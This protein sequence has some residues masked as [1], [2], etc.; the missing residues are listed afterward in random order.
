MSRAIVWKSNSR[1]V[2]DEI[3]NQWTH[4]LGFA[5]SLPAGWWLF[6]TTRETGD[7]WLVAGC[8]IYSVTLSLLYAA[9]MLSHSLHR[10]LWRHRF[11]TLDQICIFLLMAG[12]YTPF[13][14]TY[15]RNGWWG[16]LLIVMWLLALAGITAKVFFTRVHSVS[17]WFY[18]LVGWV[19]ALALPHY[20]RCLGT[21]GVAW[22]FASA[23]AY[24]GGTWFFAN[25]HRPYFHPLWHL[26]VMLGSACHYVL[27]L[28]YIVGCAIPS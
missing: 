20:F 27:T 23:A 25:D 12:S 17:V 28:K 13:G 8:V 3:L 5:A 7:A 21:E 4:G 1:F 10:G 15:L 16:V 22:I 19:P 6:R 26:S 14:M 18:L 11:R 24:S 9:S 2:T